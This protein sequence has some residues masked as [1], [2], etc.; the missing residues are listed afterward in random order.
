MTK[1]FFLMLCL[2]SGLFLCLFSNVK[3]QVYNGNLL[4]TTQ[5]EVNAFNY[6]S[7]TGILIIS[8][9]FSGITNVDSLSTLTSVGMNFLISRQSNLT[10]LNGLSNLQSVGGVL[11]ISDCPRLENLDGLSSLQSVGSLNIGGEFDGNRR[12][13]NID[14]L[15]NLVTCNSVT[16]EKNDSLTNIDG[17]SGLTNFSSVKIVENK[18]L[19]NIDGISGIQD[20][21][22]DVFIGSNNALTNVNGL[23]N[24]TEVGGNLIIQFNPTLTNLDGLSNLESVEGNMEIV[25]NIRLTS[26]LGLSDLTSVDGNLEINVNSFIVGPVTG[27]PNLN[28]LENLLS[29]GGNLEVI[30]NKDLFDFCGL[31]NLFNS[32]TI[33]GTIEIVRNG[34]NTVAVTPPIDV[35][36]NTDPGLCSAVILDAAFGTATPVGCLPEFTTTHSDFPVGNVFPVGVTQIIWSVTDGAGNTA[37]ATQNVTVVDNQNPVITCPGDITVS[38]A[39]DVPAVDIS[40]VTA[41]DNCSAVVEHVSDIISDSTCANRFTL[42]RTYKATDPAGNTATCSQVITVNDTIP[43]EITGLSVSQTALWPPNHK[44]R[45]ITVSYTISDNCLNDP[46]TTISVSSNEPVNGTGDGDTDPDWEIIDNNQIRLRAERAGTG[47]G[48]IYTITITTDDGCNPAVSA[49]T[50]VMV[51]HNITGPQSGNPFRVGSTVT[52]GGVF[53]DK[54]GNRHTAKWL[55]DNSAVANGTVT[56]PSGNQNG[57]VTGSYKFNVPGVY[58]LQMNVTD[59]NGITSYANTNGDLDAIVVIYDPNGGYTYGGGWYPSPAGALKGNPSATGKASYGFTVNYTKNATKPKGE[60][61][62]E[63]KL[64]TFEFNA[65]TFDYLSISGAKAQFRGTGKIIG[66]QSGVGFIMTVTDGN[67]DGSGVDKVR[68]KIFNK[69]NGTVYYDNQPGASDA[70]NPIAAVGANSIIVIQ[71]NGGNT[72]TTKTSEEAVREIKE[73]D[74]LE[75]TAYPNPSRTNFSVVVRSNNA[76]EKIILQVY[77]VNGRMIEIR[78]N[79]ISG[80]AVRFGDLYRPGSYYV[81]V[82]QGRERKEMKLIKV[83][84]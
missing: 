27:L 8:N 69:N 41:T 11:S 13:K 46:N 58:K 48:R 6:T 66:G 83:V 77:D 9:I 39:S 22:G 14:A 10:N 50:E 84:D 71:G 72:A 45:D 19:T 29:V 38:C 68:M 64:G 37:T 79:V 60:T 49:S 43:P 31:Y 75:L 55:V 40:S 63:F 56:E 18:A 44:M 34:T 30:A 17:L 12:L 7:V 74:G 3:A 32:G 53:Q 42:T 73:V 67:L 24:L 61:Q 82:N 54:A 23:F 20:P 59:Q 26:L 57:K 16:I 80:S 65:L 51:A 5:A 52:F 36:V 1:R 28:G 78:N 4:L 35:N 15:S 33:G 47:N 76:N 70:A 21:Q 62:F 25:G 2:Q 81:R